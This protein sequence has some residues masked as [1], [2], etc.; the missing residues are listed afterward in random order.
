MTNLRLPIK[1]WELLGIGRTKYYDSLKGTQHR[2]NFKAPSPLTVELY[3]QRA[4]V[5]RPLFNLL[6]ENPYGLTAS[7]LK[8]LIYTSPHEPDSNS[9]NTIIAKFNKK[10]K[11]HRWGVRIHGHGGPGSKYQIYVVREGC[12]PAPQTGEV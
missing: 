2:F 3:L 5:L 9:L 11:E 10:A 6:C 7:R 4:H 8:E 1:P 12:N